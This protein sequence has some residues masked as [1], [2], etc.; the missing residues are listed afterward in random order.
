[1][2]NRRRVRL[3]WSQ[4]LIFKQMLEIHHKRGILQ[5]ENFKYKLVQ[6]PTKM[7][8]RISFKG[9][10]LS[11]FL[12]GGGGRDCF[13][14]FITISWWNWPYIWKTLVKVQ[15]GI[16]SLFSLV[17]RFSGGSFHYWLF[18]DILDAGHTQRVT[19]PAWA[20]LNPRPH[21]K[22]LRAFQ[23][24]GCP[25]LRDSHLLHLR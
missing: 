7:W 11:I 9:N 18:I 1:M 3:R 20:P 19:Y 22:H 23:N 16:K 14:S 13:T 15:R 5:P 24:Y 8:T 12:F 21:Q 2:L 10:S 4:V 6:L 17:P 25:S